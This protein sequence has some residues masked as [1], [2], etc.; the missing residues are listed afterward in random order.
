M[1]QEE[2]GQTLAVLRDVTQ[3]ITRTSNDKDTGIGGASRG[4]MEKAGQKS[5]SAQ[6][7]ENRKFYKTKEEK[8]QFICE[9]FQLDANEILNANEKLK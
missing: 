6:S 1:R 2:Q 9:S 7:I 4:E 8:R 3:S 5:D